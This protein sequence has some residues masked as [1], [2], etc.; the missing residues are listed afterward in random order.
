MKFLEQEQYSLL[1]TEC[2]L[3]GTA[4]SCAGLLMIPTIDRILAERFP[5]W[6]GIKH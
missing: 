2:G 3:Q 5:S 1:R 4:L 6:P